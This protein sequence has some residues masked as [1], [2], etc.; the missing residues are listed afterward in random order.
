MIGFVNFG[1]KV[2]MYQILFNLY[3]VFVILKY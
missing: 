2:L 1:I 3:Q